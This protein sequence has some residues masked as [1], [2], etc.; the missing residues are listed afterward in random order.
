MD[1]SAG[2]SSDWRF[3][4]AG[5]ESANLFI[6]GDRKQSIYGFRGAD[7]DVFRE[8]T[9]RLVAAGGEEKPLLLNFRS[10]PPLIKFFNYL[11]ARLFQPDDEVPLSDLD[12]L[13]YVGHEASEA[14]REMRD[15]GPLVELLITTEASGDDDDPK[16]EQSSRELDAQQLAQRIIALTANGDSWDRGRPARIKQ[17]GHPSRK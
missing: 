8:M 3:R 10:Q 9:K 14:K 6:V 7:V 1:C 17:P 15:R 16:A 13:G 2:C 12:E 4:E 5:R 11:F